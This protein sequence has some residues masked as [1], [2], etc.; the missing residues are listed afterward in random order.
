MV[1]PFKC[2]RPLSI[3]VGVHQDLELA[4]IYGISGLGSKHNA[5]PA[6]QPISTCFYPSAMVLF[7]LSCVSALAHPGDNPK[8]QT[9]F[10]LSCSS[11]PSVWEPQKGE[12]NTN[13]TCNMDLVFPA[14]FGPDKKFLQDNPL[15]SFFASSKL[16][17]TLLTVFFQRGAWPIAKVFCD[18]ERCKAVQNG[19][20]YF[21]YCYLF[22]YP[23]S[24]KSLFVLPWFE[25]RHSLLLAKCA[26][27]LPFKLATGLKIP[28]K[29]VSNWI[30]LHNRNALSLC[31]FTVL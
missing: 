17:C 4:W 22:I 27:K 18:L 2:E 5:Q 10:P 19:R 20:D 15:H 26:R 11:A 29:T 21:I 8:K 1:C 24:L 23:Q 12:Q 6:P 3:T 9:K 14:C 13:Y 30:L 16:F 25:W 28:L 7:S 31:L